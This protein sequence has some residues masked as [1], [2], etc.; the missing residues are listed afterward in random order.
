MS[1]R[2]ELP[3]FKT[4]IL[5]RLMKTGLTMPEALEKAKQKYP[6]AFHEGKKEKKKQSKYRNK[7]TWVDGYCFRSKKEADYYLSLNQ[8]H[9][10]GEIAGFGVQSPEFILTTGDGKDNRAITYTADFI[11]FN[12]DGT[13]EIVDTKGVKHKEWIRIEKMMREKFPGVKIKVT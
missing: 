7:I 9:Q 11:I 1:I 12:H 10:A 8:L 13:Y 4:M 6:E 3:E 2:F 5:E